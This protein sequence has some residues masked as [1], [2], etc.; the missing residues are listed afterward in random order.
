LSEIVKAGRQRS[1]VSSTGIDVETRSQGADLGPDR[2]HQEGKNVE[3]NLKG[4]ISSTEISVGERY[5]IQS[6]RISRTEI[7]VGNKEK[8]NQGVKA[9][10]R[11]T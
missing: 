3:R 10:L 7:H 1:S 5:R 6:G 9:V 11:S 2:N 4:R 8:R